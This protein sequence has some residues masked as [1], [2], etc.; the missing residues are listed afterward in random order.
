MC[1]YCI[2]LVI[3]YIG[4]IFDYTNSIDN[5]NNNN[6]KN[7]SLVKYLFPE[8]SARQGKVCQVEPL[9]CIIYY[10]EVQIKMLSSYNNNYFDLW[11]MCV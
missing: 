6:N 8:R 11:L 7:Y 3:T 9:V 5:N 1:Y 4:I 2:I 10:I